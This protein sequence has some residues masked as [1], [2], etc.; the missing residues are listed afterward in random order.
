MS[1]TNFWNQDWMNLQQQYWQQLGEFGRKAM[2]GQEEKMPWINSD[3]NNFD[4]NQAMSQWWKTISPGMPEANKSFME[5]MLEQG[6]VFYR[7]NEQLANNL[8]KT[9]DWTEM[10]NKTFEQLQSSFASQAEKASG[11][12]AAQYMLK[13]PPMLRP[14]MA[15]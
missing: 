7:M 14:Q 11:K 6:T 2:G 10:L 8:E 4:W 15:R 1:N 3:W 13:N 9:N 5:K 12:R